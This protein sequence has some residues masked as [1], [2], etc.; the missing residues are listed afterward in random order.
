MARPS[1]DTLPLW[2]TVWAE[3]FDLAYFS[4]PTS[5]LSG[6]WDRHHHARRVKVMRFLA[7]VPP[8]EMTVIVFTDAP[9]TPL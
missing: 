2:R 8:G 1:P 5:L 6:D 7:I 4:S 3:L 9:P